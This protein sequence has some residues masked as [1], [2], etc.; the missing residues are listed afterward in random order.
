M[1]SNNLKLGL[2]LGLHPNHFLRDCP[3]QHCRCSCHSYR[4]SHHRTQLQYN[5][6][7][8]SQSQEAR[9]LL[10]IQV[11]RT[12][13]EMSI[14]CIVKTY[15][16]SQTILR[17]RMK[18]CVPKTE[19]RNARHNLISIKEETLVRYILDLDSQGFSSWINDVRD[20][21]D[22]LYKTRHI[23]SIDKQ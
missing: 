1:P 8:N 15:D 16:V 12:N 20:M 17:D 2:L 5:N 23:K 14:R 3:C 9:I 22:L 19:E 7:I 13:Q 18:D 11:I 21:I 10:V 6:T 4:L